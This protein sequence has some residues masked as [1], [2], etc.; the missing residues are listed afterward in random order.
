MGLQ[1]GCTLAPQ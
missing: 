1:K